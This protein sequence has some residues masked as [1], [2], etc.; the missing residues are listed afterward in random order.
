MICRQ[1]VDSQPAKLTGE[2]TEFDF[3]EEG[4]RLVEIVTDPIQ[5]NATRESGNADSRFIG[6]RTS[7]PS[8]LIMV[9]NQSTLIC[10][11]ENIMQP[12][13]QLK[14]ERAINEPMAMTVKFRL[15]RMLTTLSVS[16]CSN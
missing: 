4:D 9:T 7:L 5:F 14:F 8:T 1:L 16:T 13:W 2:Q 10:A 3:G 15:S 6:A 11:L 12:S